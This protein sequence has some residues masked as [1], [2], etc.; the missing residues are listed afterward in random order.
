MAERGLDNH[1][2]DE[3]LEAAGQGDYDVTYRDKAGKKA[4]GYTATFTET[5]NILC[6][7]LLAVKNE[8]LASCWVIVLAPWPVNSQPFWFTF[9]D[10]RNSEEAFWNKF[11]DAMRI[12]NEQGELNSVHGQVMLGILIIQDLAVVVIVSV[13]PVLKDFSPDNAF[14][15]IKSMITAI[16]F[17]VLVIFLAS[18]IIPRFMDRVARVENSDIF[19]L[20]ALSLGLGIALL[21]QSLGLSLS[22]GAFM[23]GMAIGESEY[24][25]EIMGK[26]V[27]LKDV[28]VVVFFVSVGMLINPFTLFQHLTAL[29]V[30]LAVILLGKFLVIFLIVWRFKYHSQV[31][32]KAAAGMMHTGEF[33]FVLARLGLDAGLISANLYNLILATALISI[34][35]APF[36]MKQSPRFYHLLMRNHRLRRLFSRESA[37]ADTAPQ[38]MNG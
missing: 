19:L 5:C 28:F 18:R 4:S 3:A 35:L 36:F 29:L 16:L 25:H 26:I 32:F 1:R 20:L 23:A 12:L 24:V 7:F 30:I 34:I 10:L 38:A 11:A 33:S 9:T 37:M 15:L 17:V 22:L 21:A 6:H 13:L 8:L 31:A 27:S 14:L 2:V